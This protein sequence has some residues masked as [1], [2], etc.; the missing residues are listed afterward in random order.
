MK[1]NKALTFD[2]IA[3]VP[4][5]SEI[6]TRSDCDLSVDL[7]KGITLSTPII[8]SP[9]KAVCEDTMAVAIGELGGMGVLH[10]F[11]TIEEQVSM[12]RDVRQGLSHL[13]K[14]MTNTYGAPIAAAI[15]VSEYEYK[16]RAGALI[17][18]GA[19]VINLDV[20]HGHHILSRTAIEYLRKTYPNLHIMSGAVCTSDAVKDL[21]QW[22]ATSIRCGIGSGC[23]TPNMKVMTNCGYKKIVDV[24]IGD[25][26]YTH[27]GN[28][29]IVV[30]KF[31]FDKDEKIII[32]NDNI[33]CT[34]NHE[35]YVINKCDESKVTENNIHNYARWIAAE[36]LTSDYLLI[37]LDVN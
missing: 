8:A 30:N 28:L 37:E 10:R 24:R 7:G 31:E 4:N 27:S 18:A 19:N 23:F 33:E 34:K 21:A 11:C 3:I 2:D 12:V 16:E 9:M 25:L 32:I 13:K 14:S 26:V 15:G 20:A 1:F 5:Y 36:K 17:V 35:L 22:G 6:T 29:E